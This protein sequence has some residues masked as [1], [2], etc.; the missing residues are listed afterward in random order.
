MEAVIEAPQGSLPLGLRSAGWGWDNG[1]VQTERLMQLAGPLA[2][3]GRI[4]ASRRARMRPPR[5]RQILY[6]T[7][8]PLTPL[9]GS[10]SLTSPH[11]YPVGICL[12]RV[13]HRR[14]VTTDRGLE[15]RIDVNANILFMH[16]LDN[17]RLRCRTPAPR[18]WCGTTL[19]RVR[20][21]YI[22]TPLPADLADNDASPSRVSLPGCHDRLRPR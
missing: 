21:D 3:S 15:R 8:S 17:V 22:G 11:R 16:A 12:R 4:G 5:R 9:G 1:E 20:P 18:A 10:G 14:L 2:L 7:G 19:L 13:R 6:S